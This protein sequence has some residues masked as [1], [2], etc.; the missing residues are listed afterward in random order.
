MQRIDRSPGTASVSTAA[1]AVAVGSPPGH[2][3]DG[4]AGRG[5]L[6]Q[7]HLGPQATQVEQA[8]RRPVRLVGHVD[9]PAGHRAEHADE[10]LRPAVGGRLVADGDSVPA[11][12][13][14]AGARDGLARRR[15][16]HR[17]EGEALG[18]RHPP[19]MPR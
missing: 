19:R 4:P 10:V 16:E 2:E 12:P 1:P 9:A 7:R 6:I 18:D 5:P 14:P 3:L 15:Q 17:D 13:E 11:H 8:P